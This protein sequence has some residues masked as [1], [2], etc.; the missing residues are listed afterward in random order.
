MTLSENATTMSDAK[1]QFGPDPDDDE[2]V[3]L[4]QWDNMKSP[5]DSDYVTVFA[6][7]YDYESVPLIPEGSHVDH[8]YIDE[9]GKSWSLE[10]LIEGKPDWFD[11]PDDP[12][13]W[14]TDSQSR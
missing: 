3:V 5:T 9:D 12:P 8:Y 14:Y 2:V 7:W 10:E 11:A 1:E 4:T 6:G 13:T